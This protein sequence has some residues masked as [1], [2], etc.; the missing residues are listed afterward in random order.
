M[1]LQG[2][3][4]RLIFYDQELQREADAIARANIA[5]YLAEAAD[6][7]AKLEGEA[8]GL[9]WCFICW[10]LLAEQAMNSSITKNWL[11]LFVR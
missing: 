4:L 10:N 2:C 1:S 3:R 5:Q 7:L 11:R 9:Q 8:V 6:D